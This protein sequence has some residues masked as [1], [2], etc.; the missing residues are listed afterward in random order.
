MYVFKTVQLSWHIL[1]W[2]LAICFKQKKKK[3]K[4][5]I[6]PRTVAPPASP[7]V[8]HLTAKICVPY[9]EIFEKMW[10]SCFTFSSFLQAVFL[11]ADDILF[12]DSHLLFQK[13]GCFKVVSL[14]CGNCNLCGTPALLK[15]QLEL[16]GRSG[17]NNLTA[18]YLI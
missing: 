4:P 15:Q 5:V 7:P 2:I 11:W 9:H 1:S 13:I 3:K 12:Q 14:W 6:C 16:W 18:H 8:P 10:H 17:Y